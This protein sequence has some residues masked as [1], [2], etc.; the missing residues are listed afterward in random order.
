MKLPMINARHASIRSAMRY[1]RVTDSTPRTIYLAAGDYCA[2]V[3]P[4]DYS[5]LTYRVVVQEDTSHP[6]DQTATDHA[7]AG[8]TV[9]TNESVVF[10]VEENQAIRVVGIGNTTY[11]HVV[12]FERISRESL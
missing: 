5:I 1:V 3:T 6:F 8:F 10:R 12:F 9:A 7:C 11:P 4:L 2:C